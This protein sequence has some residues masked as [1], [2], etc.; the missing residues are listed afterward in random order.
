MKS[1][2]KVPHWSHS[3]LKRRSVISD[4]FNNYMHYSIS[5]QL[6]PFNSVL[7]NKNVD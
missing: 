4:D 3:E 7:V 5:K 1:K 2:S 6:N